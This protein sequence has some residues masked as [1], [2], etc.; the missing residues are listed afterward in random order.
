[1]QQNCS[2]S[3]EH[4][5]LNND[6]SCTVGQNQ[7][8]SSDEQIT[9]LK[10]SIAVAKLTTPSSVPQKQCN[11]LVVHFTFPTHSQFFSSLT[12]L[13]ICSVTVSGCAWNVG[14][15]V[16][17]ASVYKWS[18]SQDTVR[19]HRSSTHHSNRTSLLSFPASFFSSKKC[20]FQQ[21]H[22]GKGGGL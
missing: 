10:P 21:E 16:C 14:G 15:C 3:F 12:M 1:M 13:C 19:R 7:K 17:V 11:S 9:A 8:Q 20:K 18:S 6:S 22:K 5:L 4:Y 2:K